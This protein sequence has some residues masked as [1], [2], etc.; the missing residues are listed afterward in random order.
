MPFQQ[1]VPI[2][3]SSSSGKQAIKTDAKGADGCQCG[4]VSLRVLLEKGAANFEMG[5]ALS[6]PYP[7]GK[8]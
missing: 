3:I 2:S 8:K 4:H 1:R 7:N 5:V 6:H